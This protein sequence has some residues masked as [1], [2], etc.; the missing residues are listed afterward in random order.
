[1]SVLLP[2]LPGICLALLITACAEPS[3][4]NVGGT[5]PRPGPACDW[6]TR[7]LAHGEKVG[8]YLAED[9][10]GFLAGDYAGMTTWAHE[11]GH[12]QIFFSVL[13][14]DNAL[15][16][17]ESDSCLPRYRVSYSL[18]GDYSPEAHAVE[19]AL[20]DAQL[21]SR[22]VLPLPLGVAPLSAYPELQ[23]FPGLKLLRLEL[24]MR[25]FLSRERSVAT[26]KIRG[27]FAKPGTPAEQQWPLDLAV[28]SVYP[29][30]E[31]QE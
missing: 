16:V 12:S 19:G 8:D 26:A 23:D 20:L 4:K 17:D 6:Q 25:W 11:A 5:T 24:S 9:I 21:S 29:A 13:A 7:P 14:S 18:G 22:G 3:P 1:M 2:G 31:L 10:V 28:V 15:T 27:F 30:S